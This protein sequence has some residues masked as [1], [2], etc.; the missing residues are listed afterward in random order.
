MRNIVFDFFEVFAHGLY[1]LGEMGKQVEK[2]GISQESYHLRTDKGLWEELQELN[3]GRISEREYWQTVTQQTDWNVSVDALIKA[4]RNAA[5]T[6]IPGTLSVLNDIDR[7][8]H[9]LF[10]LSD[11]WSELKEDL[12]KHY[13]WIETTF[14][15]A[16]FSCDLGQVKSDEGTFEYILVDAVLDGEQIE[17][18]FIDDYDVNLKQAEAAG[19]TGIL[20]KDAEQLRRDLMMHGVQFK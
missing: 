11:C 1:G 7:E 15:K 13:P 14:D 5:Y 17:T 8:Q 18:G 3:R 6:E 2:L 16:Y 10:L 20:F 4:S 12:L 19:I 9:R